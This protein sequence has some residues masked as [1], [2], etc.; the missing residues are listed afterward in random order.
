MRLAAM[1]LSTM[2]LVTARLVTATANRS[3]RAARGM[4]IWIKYQPKVP[5]CGLIRCHQ[6][7]LI[8][9]LTDKLRSR[10]CDYFFKRVHRPSIWHF[11]IVWSVNVHIFSTS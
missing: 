5:L 8:D 6:F 1:R 3:L 9:Y 10:W 11:Y 4:R 2:R 7:I